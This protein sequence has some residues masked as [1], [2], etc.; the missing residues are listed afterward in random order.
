MFVSV[1]PEEATK[2]I[3][4]GIEL[5]DVREADEF[6][7]GHIPGARLLPLSTL[8]AAPR[9]SLPRDGVLFVCAGGVRSQT[10]ARLA[11]HYGV[12][13]VYNLAGGTKAWAKAGLPIVT[14]DL[15]VAV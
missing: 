14:D 5:V 6:S 8:R 12:T 1:K 2:L 15:S 10:A 13:R 9:A 4:S 3:A 7:R 11:E